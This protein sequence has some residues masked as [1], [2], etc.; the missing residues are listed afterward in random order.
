MKT[1]DKDPKL[2]LRV[3]KIV[4][5]YKTAKADS[6]VEHGTQGSTHDCSKTIIFLTAVKL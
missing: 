4:T 1:S 2:Y 5:N 6:M 3:K